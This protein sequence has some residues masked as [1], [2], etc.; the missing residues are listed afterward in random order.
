MHLLQNALDVVT[1]RLAKYI[2]SSVISD[3]ST[4]GAGGPKP[5]RKALRGGS[6]ATRAASTAINIM[7]G[8]DKDSDEENSNASSPVR[9]T[10]TKLRIVGLCAQ[11][12]ID[13]TGQLWLCCVEDALTQFTL[14]KPDVKLVMS[15]KIAARIAKAVSGCSGTVRWLLVMRGRGLLRRRSRELLNKRTRCSIA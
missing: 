15:K 6:S 2:E 12:Y 1:K 11:Y 13:A 14:P 10:S 4:A 9:P 3:A 5:S 8:R 7:D